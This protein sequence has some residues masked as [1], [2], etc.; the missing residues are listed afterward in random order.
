MRNKWPYWRNVNRINWSVSSKQ[1]RGDPPPIQVLSIGPQ[2]RPIAHPTQLRLSHLY[3]QE[4]FQV[5]WNQSLVG[6]VDAFEHHLNLIESMSSIPEA[7]TSPSFYCQ[8]A[9]PNHRP[10]HLYSPIKDSKTMSPPREFQT[11]KEMGVH[12]LSFQLWYKTRQLN[13]RDDGFFFLLRKVQKDS[14]LDRLLRWPLETA[15]SPSGM[16]LAL[17]SPI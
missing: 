10:W 6:P 16:R 8:S 1:S 7:G 9:M 11:E 4:A 2:H 12:F 15:W 5:F 3:K 14:L 17:Q 13:E